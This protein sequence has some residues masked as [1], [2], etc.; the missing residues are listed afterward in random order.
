LAALAVACSAGGAAHAARFVAS[1]DPLFNL[2]F[3]EEVGANVGWRGTATVEVADSCLT[4][5][6]HSV[7]GWWSS[8]E[9][10][11]LESGTL[12]FYNI[13][14]GASFR[15]LAFTDPPSHILAVK[16]DSSL[17]LA[18][19]DTFPSVK[20]DDVLMFGEKW[21]V[22]LDNLGGCRFERVAQLT[23]RSAASVC[24]A[25]MAPSRSVA[26]PRAQASPNAASGRPAR[27][28]RKRS[29]QRR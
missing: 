9:S 3:N 6:I 20:F 26:D 2:D 22:S 23:T 12:T 10:A 18:G 5:G 11:S 27:N 7:G 29:S 21:D 15:D 24:A 16:I 13:D 17:T 8:C 14:G 19:I 25:A 28:R 1:F 4:P